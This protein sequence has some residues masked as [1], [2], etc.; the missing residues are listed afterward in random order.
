MSTLFSI[1]PLVSVY[2]GSLKTGSSIRRRTRV[3]GS[4]V[5]GSRVD[6][7]TRVDGT[8]VDGTGVDAT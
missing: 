8:G 6:A 4:G 2:Y 3:D 1:W 7:G 5:K